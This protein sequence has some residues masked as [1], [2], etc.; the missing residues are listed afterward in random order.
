METYAVV[1]AHGIK[2]RLLAK[3]DYEALVAGTKQLWEFPDYAHIS[4]QDPLEKKLEKV[5]KVYIDRMSLLAKIPKISD[6]VIALLD[7]LEVENI[8]FHLRFITGYQRPVLYYPY[9]RLLG[10][11]KL[12]SLSTESS[13]WEALSDT[14]LKA[15]KIPAFTTGLIAE[16][17][18]L[19]EILYYR[20]FMNTIANLKWRKDVTMTLTNFV[21]S[22]FTV[23][24]AFWTKLL[25]EDVMH[26]LIELYAPGLNV[27]SWLLESLKGTSTEILQKGM[28]VMISHAVKEI[29]MHPLDPAY[30]YILN[31]LL[32]TE[33]QNIEKILIGKEL[34]MTKEII[35]SN[36]NL[37]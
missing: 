10:L 15:P 9:S 16:R 12:K 29:R 22:N 33:A 34:G 3:Q 31:F 24:Y 35:L 30:I 6:L 4:E 26:Y 13:I 23:R 18:A 14:P 7:W 11:E 25:S 27:H 36:L 2:S 19:L 28:T 37:F 21:I 1:R 8:K 20:Y 32:L 5:Y 17:E